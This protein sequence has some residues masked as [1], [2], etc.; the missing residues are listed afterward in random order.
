MPGGTTYSAVC[1][2]NDITVA[3]DASGFAWCWGWGLFGQIGDNTNNNRNVPTSS[4]GAR[5]YTAITC[6]DGV[7]AIDFFGNTWGWGSPYSG[8]GTTNSYQVPTAA[9]MPGVAFTDLVDGG[10]RTFALDAS[11]QAWGW[12]VNNAG[13]VGDNTVITPRLIPT[14]VIMPSGQTKFT[15]IT[16]SISTGAA[17]SVGSPR[18]GAMNIGSLV[19]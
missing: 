19:L 11:G 2:G 10:V 5:A 12:G 17:L 6:D 3:L 14:A 15:A 7:H 16:A 4:A 8:D 13:Q 9:S 1:A 18:L